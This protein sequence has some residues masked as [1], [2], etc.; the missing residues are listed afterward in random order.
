VHQEIAAERLVVIA[1]EHL[2]T[3]PDELE[4]LIEAAWDQ[5]N[6]GD[7]LPVRG[8]VRRFWRGV[9]DKVGAKAY[10]NRVAISVL[11]GN[12]AND[13]LELGAAHG[14]DATRYEI[15]LGLLVALGTQGV[16]EQLGQRPDDTEHGD[17]PDAGP[18]AT[19]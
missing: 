19:G 5:A 16:L 10:D 13:V 7:E 9:K 11:M 18:D 6:R 8:D 1:R 15:F 2:S 3:P 14:L 4:A 17:D 12:V